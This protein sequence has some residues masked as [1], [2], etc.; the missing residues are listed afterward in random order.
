MASWQRLA[1]RRQLVLRNTLLNGQCFNWREWGLDGKDDTSSEETGVQSAAKD[2]SESSLVGVVGPF[3]VQLRENGPCVEFAVLGSSEGRTQREDARR[4]LHSYF[5]L[6]TDVEVLYEEWTKKCPRMEKIC[7]ALPGM[8][9]LMQDPVE[10][11][12]SFICSSNNNIARIKLML[13][14]LRSRFGSRIELDEAVLK[15]NPNYS[16]LE[17]YEFPCISQLQSITEEDL[18]TMGFGYRAAYLVE[19]IRKV[20]TEADGAE[21][22]LQ[23]LRKL[24]QGETSDFEIK[25]S[26][27]K[28]SGVGPKVADCVAL[29]CL[30]RHG[31]IPVDTHVWQVARRDMDRN[32]VEVKSITPKVYKRVGDLFREKYGSYAGWAHSLLFSAELPQFRKFLPEE[33]QHE[34]EEFAVEMKE[35][36][37][38]LKRQREAKKQEKSHEEKRSKAPRRKKT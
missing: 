21:T 32:L 9:V 13:D 18:R 4:Q 26:L 28:L 38:S 23:G 7:D 19:T 24:E 34:I 6:D 30:G 8:R 37:A 3:A 29:F 12:I 31:A 22:W 1:S 25:N 2:A 20:S 14:S 27:V 35:R 36:K 33:M 11:L 15:D 5:Q 16:E 10:C 17:L